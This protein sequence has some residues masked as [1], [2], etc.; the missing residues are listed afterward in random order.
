MASVDCYFA[1][2]CLIAISQMNHVAKNL[3]PFYLR[4]LQNRYCIKFQENGTHRV[5]KAEED[6]SQD[7]FHNCGK[8]KL[9]VLCEN[10]TFNRCAFLFCFKT[11][12]KGFICCCLL[13]EELY[14][15]REI[16]HRYCTYLWCHVYS[17]WYV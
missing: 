5:S 14:R 4:F 17:G 8:S 2:L 12:K 10:I 13:F 11:S 15:L 3:L 6:E 7:I 9:A 1:L 16:P